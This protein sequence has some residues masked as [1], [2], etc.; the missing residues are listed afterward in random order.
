MSYLAFSVFAAKNRC[1]H[2][3]GASGPC[4]AMSV[5]ISLSF[6]FSDYQLS[7]ARSR[8]LTFCRNSELTD[9]YMKRLC[10][11]QQCEN[12][13]VPASSSTRYSLVY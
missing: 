9:V 3:L 7:L 1:S 11:K 13:S 5:L 10:A 6:F 8:V 12:F 2:F 4:S